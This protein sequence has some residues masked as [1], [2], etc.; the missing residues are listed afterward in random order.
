MKTH[1]L[2]LLHS[3]RAIRCRRRFIFKTRVGQVIKSSFDCWWN[4][5]CRRESAPAQ[6]LNAAAPEPSQHNPPKVWPR[7]SRSLLC[8]RCSLFLALFLATANLWLRAFYNLSVPDLFLFLFIAFFFIKLGGAWRN[9][10]EFCDWPNLFADAILSFGRYIKV[11][12]ET[13]I[14]FLVL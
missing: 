11:V 7:R 10:L 4:W 3:A 6:A 8:R 12:C 13:K 1:S 5:I 9:F 2:A 14:T